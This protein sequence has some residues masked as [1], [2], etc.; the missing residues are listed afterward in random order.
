MLPLTM[1]GVVFSGLRGLLLGLWGVLG[2]PWAW[3]FDPL[4]AIAQQQAQQAQSWA[5]REVFRLRVVRDGSGKQRERREEHLI[6][7]GW[8]EERPRYQDAKGGKRE[9]RK[10]MAGAELNPFLLRP[11]VDLVLQGVEGGKEGDAPIRLYRFR[12]EHPRWGP[13][14]G[15][16]KL[17]EPEGSPLS[18]EYTLAKL[19][20]RVKDFHLELAFVP[21]RVGFAVPH[22]LKVKLH[23]KAFL[24][25][26]LVEVRETYAGWEQRGQG[27]RCTA[28]AV[29]ASAP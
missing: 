13:M 15:V 11:G 23:L 9:F 2:V 17:S 24:M 20:A 1:G 5:P 27:Q 28:A 25:T 18:L 29:A 7:A 16:A 26:L 8:E 6:F 19:P 10:T 22:E 3:A 14:N 4:W 12:Q 21:C